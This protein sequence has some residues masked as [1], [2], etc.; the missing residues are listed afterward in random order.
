MH[1][2]SPARLRGILRTGRPGWRCVLRTPL[3][4]CDFFRQLASRNRLVAPP[5]DRIDEPLVARPVSDPAN[6]RPVETA[7]PAG[8]PAPDP[9]SVRIENDGS[10]A[11]SFETL[12]APLLGPLG[13]AGLAVVL[14]VFM[15][16]AREDLRNRLVTL[17]GQAH[18][19]TTTKALDEA[20]RG[21]P[22]IC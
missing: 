11:E 14:V 16:L 12:V 20:G 2:S 22:G 18:V 9:V 17:S 8:P 15:L 19:V 10:L 7:A 3:P 1:S 6:S 13:A 5:T 21:S 4:T